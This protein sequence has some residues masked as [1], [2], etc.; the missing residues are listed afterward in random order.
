MQ[1]DIDMLDI[2]AKWHDPVLL[3]RC[4]R[5][6]GFRA[7][8]PAVPDDP[9]LYAFIQR[10]DGAATPLYVGRSVTVR[11]RL[12]S[13][14][15]QDNRVAR[16]LRKIVDDDIL[17]MACTVQIRR[18]GKFVALRKADEDRDRILELL[19][20]ALIARLSATHRLINI[21]NTKNVHS[22]SFETNG[23]AEHWSPRRLNISD[24][25]E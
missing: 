4:D 7:N 15:R 2:Q 19:E 6:S 18:R 20:T 25:G 22:I 1:G 16:A 14:M 24:A 3:E 9:G 23:Y 5:K 17:F 11:G 13:Y 10:Q 8:E 21:A 12:N